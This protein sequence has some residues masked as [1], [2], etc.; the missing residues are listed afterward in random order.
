M[1]PQDRDILVE[2]SSM[3]YIHILFETPCFIV[4]HEESNS[5]SLAESISSY[6][7][8]SIRKTYVGYVSDRLHIPITNVNTAGRS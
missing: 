4:F 5:S 7:A 1:G 6:S 8:E 2:E 3:M